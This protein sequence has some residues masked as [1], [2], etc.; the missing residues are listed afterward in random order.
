VNHPLQPL[1]NLAAAPM[2]AQALQ[3]AIAL[4]LFEHLRQ[5]QPAAAVA[6]TLRLNPETTAI[7]LD[8]LW[9]M[10]LLHRHASA[11]SYSAD[12]VITTLTAQFFCPSSVQDCSAAW[13][14]RADF[15]N[16]F[17]GQWSSLLHHGIP[18]PDAPQPARWAQAART[19]L[20][21]EQ[22]TISAVQLPA[23]L[24]QLPLLPLHGRFADIG[25]GP[26]HVAVALAH[27]LP[28]WHG[29]VVEQAHTA[30]VAQE[31]I[32]A[33]GLRTRLTT[34]TA[35]LNTD[36]AIGSDYDL[37]WCSS[38]LH[39]VREPAKTVQQLQAALAPEGRLLLAH[40]EV[41]NDPQQAAAILPFYAGVMLR[42]GYL[43][44]SGEI[45][46]WMHRAGLSDIRTLGNI[47][48][49]LAPLSVYSG[50]RV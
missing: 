18:K 47:P 39:F 11:D 29:V 15:L 19:H 24:K 12:Y 43:P 5:P 50:R 31:T 33:A 32:N 35:D 46:N 8:V 42:G 1:W 34:L 49:A 16:A 27:Y 7:W 2:L 38:V 13:Q 40:A 25:G 17:S 20:G 21:Q 28:G 14:A 26:G 37:I 4:R 9:S 41:A 22:Q 30:E 10:G 3:Q 6:K 36:D 23:L 45:S 44:R 48:W